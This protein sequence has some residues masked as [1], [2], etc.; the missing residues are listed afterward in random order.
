M[1]DDLITFYLY[2]LCLLAA[3]IFAFVVV[4]T[5]VSIRA[6]MKGGNFFETL[7]F[8]WDNY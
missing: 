5:C 3:F 4:V 6:K 7:R 1:S 2:M 8:C